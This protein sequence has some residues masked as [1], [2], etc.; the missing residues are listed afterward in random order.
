M[1]LST[2]ARYALA[3]M[4]AIAK[5]ARNRERITL[6]EVAET[7]N[8]PRRY[9]EQLAIALK[10]SHLIAGTIG[11]GGGYNLTRPADEI[12]VGQ[13]IEAAIG[14]IGIVD[15]VLEPDGCGESGTCERR[16]LYSLINNRIT[17][18][19]SSIS[20]ADLTEE[21]WPEQVMAAANL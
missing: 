13:I 11:R 21:R 20:L 2:R 10:Q 15:C 17:D 6:K 8:K 7:T 18:V 14:P 4:V 9:L 16:P 19:L 12:N 5:A 3:M 1:K